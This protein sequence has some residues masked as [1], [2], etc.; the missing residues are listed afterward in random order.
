M[1]NERLVRWEDRRRDYLGGLTTLILGLSSASIAFCGSLLTQDSVRFSG[2]RAVLFLSAVA[3]LVLALL[4]SLLAAFSRLQDARATAN[5][6]RADGKSVTDGYLER[7]RN[8]AG[9]WGS[10]T[11]ALLYFQLILFSL[12]AGLL[13]ATLWLI[14]RSKLFP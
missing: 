5:I 13:L 14:F 6:V 7:L 4:A 3:C 2:H 12:G 10:L 9:F 8:K 11:W 1:S